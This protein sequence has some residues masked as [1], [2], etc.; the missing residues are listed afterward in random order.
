MLMLAQ[1][2]AQDAQVASQGQEMVLDHPRDFELGS[3]LVV[4]AADAAEGEQIAGQGARLGEAAVGGGGD[5]EEMKRLEEQMDY[6]RKTRS[7][8]SP[9]SVTRE[10]LSTQGKT[11]W[12]GEQVA[13]VKLGK[14]KA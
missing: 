9:V 6:I 12:Q 1:A 14:N 8:G 7:P 5:V 13:F 4:G 2:R 10:P 11:F 3:P